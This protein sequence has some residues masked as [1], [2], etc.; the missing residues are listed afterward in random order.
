MILQIFCFSCWIILFGNP[1]KVSM[2]WDPEMVKLSG[3]Q[4]IRG[5]FPMASKMIVIPIS[6][7]FLSEVYKVG[8][9]VISRDDDEL[10]RCGFILTSFPGSFQS[11]RLHWAD[12]YGQRLH[13][14]YITLHINDNNDNDY[15]HDDE[16]DDGDDNDDQQWWEVSFICVKE[17]VAIRWPPLVGVHTYYTMVLSCEMIIW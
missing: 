17:W 16:Y 12:P 15:E 8:T 6:Q 10:T 13:N 3:G 9:F 2:Y 5:N 14:H 4:S 7:L 1:W 11:S